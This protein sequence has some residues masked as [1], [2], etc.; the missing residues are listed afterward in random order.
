M[1]QAIIFDVDD[2]LY[3]QQ[4]PFRKAVNKIAPL[5]SDEDMSELYIR[6]RYYSD[7]NFP[8]VMAGLM[9]IDEMRAD[10]IIQSIKDLDYPNLT[11]DEALHFQKIYEDELACITMHHDKEKTL[12]YLAQKKVP[13]GIITNGPT[14][15]QAKK[16]KQLNV[17]KWVTPER[18][19]ISEQ[20][21]YQK[22]EV[23]IFKLAENNF[24]YSGEEILYVGDS[25]ESDVTGSKKANWRALWFNHRNRDLPAGAH[26]IFDVEINTFDQLYATVENLF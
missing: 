16:I 11:E 24:D 10:R 23:E 20:T 7:E 12:N 18:T 3:D 25:F 2:T 22:P 9:T 13:I 5:V 17:S 21:G 14:D 26:P 19:M 1:I 15:H 4:A 8:K 6:F